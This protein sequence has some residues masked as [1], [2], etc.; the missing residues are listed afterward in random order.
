[1][2]RELS[3][4]DESENKRNKFKSRTMMKKMNGLVKRAGVGGPEID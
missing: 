1:M 2:E 3:Q 4:T